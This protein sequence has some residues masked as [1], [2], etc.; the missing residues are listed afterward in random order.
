ML[1]AR[2]RGLLEAPP[3]PEGIPGRRHAGRVLFS[4][5]YL[6]TRVTLAHLL[7]FYR[8]NVYK[9]VVS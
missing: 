3:G 9:R 6:L 8:L 2:V 4:R 7:T 1:F 5:V